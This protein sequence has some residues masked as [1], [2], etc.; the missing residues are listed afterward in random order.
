MEDLDYSE[1]DSLQ[2]LHD[3]QEFQPMQDHDWIFN[4]RTQPINT[5]GSGPLQGVLSEGQWPNAASQWTQDLLRVWSERLTQSSYGIELP[6]QQASIS[7]LKG[8][9]NVVE[10]ARN[11][12][13]AENHLFEDR[14]VWAKDDGGWQL[15]DYSPIVQP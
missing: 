15:W 3:I 14:S 11:L 9:T 7:D 1:I 2:L 5:I 12:I 13:E 6:G 10:S 4:L 8:L